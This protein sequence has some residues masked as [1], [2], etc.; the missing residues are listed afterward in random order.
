MMSPD[1]TKWIERRDE[2]LNVVSTL[3]SSVKTAK[4]IS[5]YIQTTKKST[6][7]Y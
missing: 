3:A 7:T 4:Q 5:K 2:S 1:T 6:L